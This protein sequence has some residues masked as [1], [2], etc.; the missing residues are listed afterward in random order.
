LAEYRFRHAQYRLDPQL[1]AASAAAPYIVTFDD[2]EIV[3]NWFATTDPNEPRQDRFA[4]RRTA[5]FQAFYEHLPLRAAAR[6]SSHGMKIH[7]RLK[8]GKLLD[9]FMLDT[10][11]Y[12]SPTPCGGG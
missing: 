2:H 12:R 9:L 3:D 1:R 5:A 8:W 7:R 11:Q 6:P 4:P 10:R